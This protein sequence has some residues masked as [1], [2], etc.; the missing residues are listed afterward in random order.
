[1]IG[2]HM[3]V[4]HVP[5]GHPCLSRRPKVHVDVLH[6]IDDRTDRMSTAA[7]EIR[8][9]HR[10]LMKKLPEDHARTP[11]TFTPITPNFWAVL[12]FVVPLKQSY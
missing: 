9:S 5:N 7:E 4:K 11:E 2:V 12:S 10:L 6:W 3:R 8:C 1:M